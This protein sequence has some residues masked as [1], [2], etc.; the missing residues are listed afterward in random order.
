LKIQGVILSQGIITNV[1]DEPNSRRGFL[2]KAAIFTGS[3]IL[4]QQELF[5][6]CPT[7]KSIK[8][9]N[10]HQ[11]KLYKAE[12]YEKDCYKLSGLFEVNKAFIDYRA[13][14][15][16]RIDIDLINLLYDIGTHIGHD[17]EF[18]VVSGYR[19]KN[20]NNMLRRH[21]SGVAKD[22]YHTKGKAVDIYVPGVKLRKLRD[23]AI[24]LGRGGV[25][26]YPRSNFIHIDVG[27]VRTWRKG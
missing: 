27:P 2:K 18:S 20:T 10:I 16:T 9:R 6:S 8:L 15:I 17:K 11:N 25:G 24:G 1:E 3:A 4:T 23:I 21:M 19:S 14:E 5:A 7:V 22:S 12:F 13:H 26:Y